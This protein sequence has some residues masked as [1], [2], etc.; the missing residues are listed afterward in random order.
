VLSRD[1][2][3]REKRKEDWSSRLMSARRPN[4]EHQTD[5]WMIY[6]YIDP[7]YDA[8][9]YPK[10]GNDICYLC[11]EKPFLFFPCQRI[12]IDPPA[13]RFWYSWGSSFFGYAGPNAGTD[14]TVT[15]ESVPSVWPCNACGN[16]PSGCFSY[17][18]W[19]GPEGSLFYHLCL[20]P[21]GEIKTP[22]DVVW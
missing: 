10:I 4:R 1:T 9:K 22:E 11:K 2:K 20:F 17:A 13:A 15:T 12:W 3:E 16:Y 8:W 6:I 14:S 18:G 21:F 7:Y 19:L 5:G